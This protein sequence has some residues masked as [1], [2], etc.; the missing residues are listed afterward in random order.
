TIVER[1]CKD[2]GIAVEKAEIDADL[3]ETLKSVPGDK[4]LFLD[5]LLRQK[6]MT[7]KEWKD[8]VIRPKLLM[9]KFCR[10][11]I[12]CNEEEVN[13]A[14]ES[15]YG[16]K[17]MVQLIIWTPDDVKKNRPQEVYGKICSDKEEFDL[18]ARAQWD[19]KLASTAGQLKP[20]GRYSQ[21]NQE[22]E[23][24]A[25]KMREGQITPV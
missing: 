15:I 8:D 13:H 3:A 16:D 2:K 1:A 23:A 5:N 6:Q 24:L 22:M 14:F 11:R 25:F 4:R 18:E 21:D 17:V 20:F 12:G 7:L 10:D 19:K 9:N